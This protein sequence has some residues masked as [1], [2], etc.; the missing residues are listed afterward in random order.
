MDDRTTGQHSDGDRSEP[1]SG[2]PPDDPPPERSRARA[3]TLDQTPLVFSTLPT[4]NSTPEPSTLSNGSW[5]EPPLDPV[6]ISIGPDASRQDTVQIGLWGSARSGKTTYLSAIPIA[7]MQNAGNSSN[8]V[9]SG[10]GEVERKTLTEGVDLLARG[11]RFPPRTTAVDPLT[12]SFMGEEAGG[13]QAGKVS[14]S[15]PSRWWRRWRRWPTARS[16][17]LIDFALEL[18]DVPGEYYQT[19]KVDPRVVD[20]L[21]SSQALLYLFDPILGAAVDT[22]SFAF[23]HATLQEVAA[24]VRDEGRLVD[25]RLPHYVSVCVTKFDDPLFFEPAVKAGWVNQEQG[26]S[27]LP[28]IPVEQGPA[29]FEWMCT[30]FHGG[31]APLVRDAL[32]SYFHPDRIEYFASSAIGFRLNP[33]GMFDYSDYANVEIIDGEPR[34]KSLPRPVNVLEPLIRLE[35][36]IR[37]GQGPAPR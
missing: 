27:Q 5:S 7:A 22:E 4:A 30:K 2:A 14:A 18:Q 16:T 12:W 36:R 11:R 19:G 8:W 26:D 1:S 6:P 33:N 25:N 15:E 17:Q 9:V 13:E 20:H 37:R 24:R 29:F 21:A 23:F 28:K 3:E 31:N 32:G 10:L 34:I 35:R